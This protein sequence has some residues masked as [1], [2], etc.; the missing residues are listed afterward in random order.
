M[1]VKDRGILQAQNTAVWPTCHTHRCWQGLKSGTAELKERG[2]GGEAILS[3]Q[4]VEQHIFPNS[5]K[6]LNHRK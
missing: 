2:P 1:H 3:M 5:N 4:S 6:F